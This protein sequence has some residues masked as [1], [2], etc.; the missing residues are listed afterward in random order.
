ME[1]FRRVR[2]VRF[3]VL[4]GVMMFGLLPASALNPQAAQAGAPAS[5]VALAP[6]RVFDTRPSNRVTVNSTVNVAVLDRAGVPAN[7]VAAVFVNVTAVDAVD[8]GF[9]TVWPTGT[10]R[11]TASML[12]VGA[13]GTVANGALVRVGTGGSISVFSSTAAHVLVDVQ[14]YVPTGSPVT[15]RTPARLL[16]TR[17]VDSTI[18]SQGA[19]AGRTTAKAT[20]D[21][22]VAGRAGVPATG[23]AGVFVNVVAVDPAEAGFLTTWPTGAAMPNASTANYAVGQTVANNAYVGLGA[24]GKISVFSQAAAHLIVDIIGYVP[25]NAAP[26]PSQPARLLDTRKTG[27]TV[28]TKYAAGELLRPISELSVV[29]TG[30]GGVPETGAGAVIVNVTAVDPKDDGFVTAWATGQQRPTASMLNYRAKS[31]VANGTIVAIGDGGRISLY[32]QSSTNVLVDVVGWLP[33]T[34]PVPKPLSGINLSPFIGGPPALPVTPQLVRELTDRVAPYTKWIR[35]YECAGGFA[36][37]PAEAR[38]HGLKIA[39]GG[40]LSKDAAKNRVEVDCVIRQANAGNADL[41]VIGNEVL[42]RGDLT[43][44]ALLAFVNEVKA[45]VSVPVTTVDTDAVLL[46]H[47]NLMA[48]VEEVFANIYPY[49]AGVGIESA[50]ANLQT[51]YAA[52]KTAAGTKAVTISETGWPSCGSVKGGASPSPG[53]AARYLAGV[54]AWANGAGVSY[55]WMEAYDQAFKA[56]FSAGQADACFG[57]WTE[58][59]ELKPGMREAFNP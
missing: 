50:V 38:A 39:L 43:E 15:V 51:T 4:V 45:A 42:K 47:P 49:W 6:S 7:D 59:G 56:S 58:G 32:T 48:A 1:S 11:P 2:S 36:A 54:T 19:G 3:G 5:Y 20:T 25:L 52:V 53:N 28:D 24:G 9:L 8:A 34:A 21:V 29:V 33:G 37:F 41:V 13:G 35:T 40:W 22:V 18:D 44:S 12:N 31:T 23:V 14:G 30:R 57:L 26:V 27:E 10:T 16:D 55:F 17:S 46:A